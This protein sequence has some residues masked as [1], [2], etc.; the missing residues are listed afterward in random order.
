MDILSL[1]VPPDVARWLEAQSRATGRSKSEIIREAVE[2]LRD[3]AR[4]GSALDLA[5][6]AVGRVASGCEDLGSNK[7]RLRGFGR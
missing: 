4:S 5:G 1:K 7:K 6:D 2:R 3:A